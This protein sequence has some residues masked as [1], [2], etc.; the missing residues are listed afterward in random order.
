V[1]IVTDCY[2]EQQKSSKEC[3]FVGF[4]SAMFALKIP[5]KFTGFGIV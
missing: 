4:L 1:K 5:Q 2:K 3:G